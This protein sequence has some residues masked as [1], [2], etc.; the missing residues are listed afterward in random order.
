[1][2]G[3][4]QYPAPGSPPPPPRAPGPAY[5]APPP[6]P[7]G[8]P[9]QPYPAYGAPAYGAPPAPLGAAHKPGAIPLRPLALGD[10]YDAAFRI[11]RLNPKATVGSAVLVA[12]VSMA[13]PVVLTTVLTFAVGAAFDPESDELSG[14]DLVG[15]LGAFGSLGLGLVLQ[16]LGLILVT[17]M[18]AHVVSAATVGQRLSLGEAWTRTH[19]KRWRLVGLSML[20]GLLT[21]LL[22]ATYALSW[23]LVALTQEWRII[24]PYLLTIPLFLAAMCWFWVRVYLLPVPALMLEPVG[25]FG[26]LGRGYRLTEGRQFW[27]VFGIALLTVIITQIGGSML[28]MPFAFLTQIGAVAGA[29]T[30]YYLLLL[31][32]GQALS[33]VVTAAFVSPVTACVTTLQYV[34]QRIRREAYDVELMTRAGLTRA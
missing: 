26:S 12:A 24:V 34:D 14:T 5:G 33:S 18:I 3:S 17:G 6:G 1:M 4:D 9:T 19:G 7:Y 30:Q 16:S 23:V 21:M 27:R 31:V 32:L 20:L 22:V 10:I 8:A 15:A 25:V 2:S 29:G 28:S 13:L 11:I